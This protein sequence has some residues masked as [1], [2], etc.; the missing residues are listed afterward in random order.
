[1]K[2]LV[3]GFEPFGSDTYNPSM[4]VLKLLEAESDD[5]QIE[6]AV[7]P[8]AKGN[9]EE[10]IIRKMESVHPAY[11]IMLGLAGG[12]KGIT[13]ER[14]AIN[15]DDFRIP[16]ANGITLHDEPIDSAG[17][18]AYFSGL[19]Y[20]DM[21]AAMKE[22]GFDASLSESAGTY[23]CNHVFYALSNY[24]SKHHLPVRCGFIHLPYEESMGY[25]DRPSMKL[26]EMGKALC[27]ALRILNK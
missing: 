9:A 19:P 1:M 11:V 12:R 20:R 25:D 21:I 6:T 18:A 5:P 10:A 3:T 13:V 24:I 14:T 2:I 26:E 4:E 8:V 27:A 15:I 16:D 7:I 23:I 22:A 17:P